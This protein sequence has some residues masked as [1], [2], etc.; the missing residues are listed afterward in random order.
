MGEAT[1]KVSGARQEGDIRAVF[2]IFVVLT[3]VK[4][5]HMWRAIEIDDINDL[6][7]PR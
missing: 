7:E 2:S 6:E 1:L 3:I 4:G 5:L